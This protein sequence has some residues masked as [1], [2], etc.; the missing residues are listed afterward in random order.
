MSPADGPGP[1][2]EFHPEG[3]VQVWVNQEDSLW[4]SQDD[5]NSMYVDDNIVNFAIQ[6]D[7][8]L[9]NI[10]DQ[11]LTLYYQNGEEYSLKLGS[12][13]DVGTSAEKWFLVLSQL[14][15][16]ADASLSPMFSVR[17]TPNLW[18]LRHGLNILVQ[19][20]NDQRIEIA[21]IVYSFAKMMQASGNMDMSPIID[22]LRNSQSSSAAS[23]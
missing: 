10:D 21:S 7:W 8:S 2:P 9:V 12:I 3:S 6:P 22:D 17:T 18:N 16:P 23:S 20:L 14:I 5:F 11:M 4:Y 1:T 19:Q 13:A 15:I